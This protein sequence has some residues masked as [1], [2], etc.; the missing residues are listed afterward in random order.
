MPAMNLVDVHYGLPEDI[1]LMASSW[2]RESLLFT[3][4]SS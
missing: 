2:S 3:V 1:S 4:S